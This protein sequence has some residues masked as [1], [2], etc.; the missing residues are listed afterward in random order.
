MLE[1]C[2]QVKQCV[3]VMF[4]YGLLSRC[5]NL[6]DSVVLDYIDSRSLPSFLH[7]LS[8]RANLSYR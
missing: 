5:V 2:W 3:R 8:G 1:S 4:V 6:A 7:L